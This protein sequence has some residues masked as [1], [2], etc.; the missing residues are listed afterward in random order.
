MSREESFRDFFHALISLM[1]EQGITAVYNFENPEMLGLSSM[2]ADV[3]ASSLVDNIVL[4]N[5][6]ELGDTF[7]HALTV[8]K[9]R[10]M[11]TTRVTHECEISDGRGMVVLP[12][13]VR[14]AIPAVPFA[15]YLGLLSR[16]PE[17]HSPEGRPD[18]A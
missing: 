6:F 12:R 3:R 5:W 11:P 10:A 15:S 4:L 14:L 1:R 16:A 8:A 7:R 9:M 13:E 17:R 18:E 2:L